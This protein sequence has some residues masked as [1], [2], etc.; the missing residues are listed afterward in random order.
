[1]EVLAAAAEQMDHVSAEKLLSGI[2]MPLLYRAVAAVRGH[3]A[4]EMPLPSPQ[5]ITAGAVA[6][7]DSLS[8]EVV[9]TFCALLGGYAGNVALTFGAT[10]GV[11]IGGGIATHLGDLLDGG[12]FRS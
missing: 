10:G 5:E 2:G 6:G 4:A 3:G 12:S 9:E 7:N 8:I 11:L 1:R